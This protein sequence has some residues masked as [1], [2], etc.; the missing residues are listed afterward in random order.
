MHACVRAW[1]TPEL[2]AVHA[3]RGGH[4]AP[5]QPPRPGQG[6][7]GTSPTRPSF[8]ANILRHAVSFRSPSADTDGRDAGTARGAGAVWRALAAR[9]AAGTDPQHLAS[10]PQPERDEDCSEPRARQSRSS[11]AG[12]P[13]DSAAVFSARAAAG[14]C[15]G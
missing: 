7:P 5:R 14:L 15:V 11:W 9:R 2:D 3:D 8:F 6:A 13:P 1:H 12:L 4:Q 10:G